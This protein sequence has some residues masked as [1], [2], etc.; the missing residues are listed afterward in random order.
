M[1]GALPNQGLRTR[2][3]DETLA[4]EKPKANPTDEPRGEAKGTG[5]E[6][7]PHPKVRRLHLPHPRLDTRPEYSC[8][9]S[10]PLPNNRKY[11]ERQNLPKG[12]GLGPA[13]KNAL[14]VS[15]RCITK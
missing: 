8:E 1:Q 3:G 10:P 6:A 7:F 11:K 9:Y 14:K 12:G 2:K 13:P 5:T 4:G 15:T